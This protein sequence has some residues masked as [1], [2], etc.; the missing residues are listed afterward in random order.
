VAPRRLIIDFWLWFQ[1]VWA[2]RSG[3]R[4]AAPAA[5]YEFLDK[6]YEHPWQVVEGKGGG[7]LIIG[8]KTKFQNIF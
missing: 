1:N 8:F 5:K 2:R 4:R 3:E 7:R 6:V